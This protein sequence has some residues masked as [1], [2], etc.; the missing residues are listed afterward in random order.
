[1]ADLLAGVDQRTQLVGHNRIELLLFR[2]EGKQR[3]GINVFKVQEVI[4]CPPLTHVPNT[5]SMICG[6]AT[7]RE[8]TIPV[9]DLGKAIGLQPI[10]NISDKFIV[11]SEFNHAV[12]GFIVWSVDKI[13]NKP[14]EEILPPPAGA[15]KD[16]YVISVTQIEKELIEII[17][18]EKVRAEI[19]T[20]TTVPSDDILEQGKERGTD[21]LDEIHVLVVDDSSVARN[22][23]KRTLEQLGMKCTLAKNGREALEMLIDWHTNDTEMFNKVD[24]VLSDIEMPEMDGY[25][26][27]TKIREDDRLAGKYIILHSSLSG[28]FN[29]AMVEKVGA[30]KFIAKYNPDELAKTVLNACEAI[31]L[32]RREALA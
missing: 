27:T 19:I 21:E 9:I 12:I 17:D 14:W 1:M 5:H 25:T 7:I 8:K 31:D 22:Q 4:Q 13:V 20:T 32:A 26:L 15:G 11:V 2:L 18:V 29:N 30:D 3:Y 28:V 24:L 16:S 10:E 6:V 23:V